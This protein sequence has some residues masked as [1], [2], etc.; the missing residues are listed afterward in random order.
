[1]SGK[2]IP[3]GKL[4]FEP[5]RVMVVEESLS[6]LAVNLVVFVVGVGSVGLGGSE[7]DIV[8]GTG[9]GL[10]SMFQSSLGW[11]GI[12]WSPELVV[13]VGTLSCE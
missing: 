3:A 4:D 10:R 6:R 11:F 1:M 13:V 5:S 12:L 8:Y 9:Y 7:V 2:G